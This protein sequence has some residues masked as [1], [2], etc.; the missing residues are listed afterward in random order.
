MKSLL[1]SLLIVILSGLAT[2]NAYSEK[3][4]FEGITFNIMDPGVADDSMRMLMAMATSGKTT[5]TDVGDGVYTI[6]I[7]MGKEEMSDIL[8]SPKIVNS[9]LIEFKMFRQPDVKITI[10]PEKLNIG[11]K[12]VFGLYSSSD[13]DTLYKN[14]NVGRKN[15]GSTTNKKA[16][17]AKTSGGSSLLLQYLRGPFGLTPSNPATAGL[18]Q[19]RD[20]LKQNKIDFSEDVSVGRV[21]LKSIYDRNITL[22][23]K[24]VSWRVM[25]NIRNY[26]IQYTT[27][28]TT[29]DQAFRDFDE[30]ASALKAGGITLEQDRTSESFPKS[31]KGKYGNLKISLRVYNL[32]G[33]EY[34]VDLESVGER[35]YNT[36]DYEIEMAPTA[37]PGFNV[38]AVANLR[39]DAPFDAIE[40]EFK[41]TLSPGAIGKGRITVDNQTGS[42]KYIIPLQPSL[43]S[44]GLISQTMKMEDKP[45]FRTFYM[46]MQLWLQPGKRT[47]IKEEDKLIN[48]Q[49]AEL[50]S[51]LKSQYPSMQ[52]ANV[53]DLKPYG[54]DN[55]AKEAWMVKEGNIT[56][57]YILGK[58]KVWK[59]IY[60][61]TVYKK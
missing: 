53:K 15:S 59:Y 47:T 36:S 6:T 58:D 50:I 57:Y 55:K 60:I 45:T 39:L 42:R 11:D 22:M 37:L 43:L 21:W 31:V 44:R 38:F 19:W 17:G 8:V 2:L 1:K 25:L 46:P 13:F 33:G 3:V 61:F 5:I 26:E 9:K 29:R 14:L 12:M 49:Y 30:F 10:T 32:G 34:W 41:L 35:T 24:A 16:N 27:T 28:K 20:V 18:Q 23:G 54:F 48:E 56:N 7:R 52:K 4:I 40:E 51:R